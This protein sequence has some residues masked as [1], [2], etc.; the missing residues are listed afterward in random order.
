MAGATNSARLRLVNLP[1]ISGG[2]EH[3]EI[4]ASDNGRWWVIGRYATNRVVLVNIVTGTVRSE[5]SL[6]RV[7]G[8]A[9][10][11]TDSG[12]V[13]ADPHRASYPDVALDRTDGRERLYVKKT[14][15]LLSSASDA[16]RTVASGFPRLGPELA[17]SFSDGAI[18]ESGHVVTLMTTHGY[19]SADRNHAVDVYQFDLRS[20]RKT[21]V[22]RAGSA[23]G[24]GVAASANGRFVVFDGTP[25]AGTAPGTGGAREVALLWDRKDHRT[26]AVSLKDNGRPGRHGVTGQFSVT[27]DGRVAFV[28][29]DCNL[30]AAAPPRGAQ[31]CLYISAPAQPVE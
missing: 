1:I 13:E 2:D 5:A 29:N 3:D 7:S 18:S 17:G 12:H 19:D 15:I 16:V 9:Y 31:D 25:A 6:K 28:S 23:S 11:V 10:D 21:W 24:G 4:G 8:D 26:V 27:D 14:T 22:S 20:G 30:T